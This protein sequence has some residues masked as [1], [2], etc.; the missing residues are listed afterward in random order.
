MDYE[1]AIR[2]VRA[3]ASELSRFVEGSTTRT[4]A[5]RPVDRRLLRG[6]SASPRGASDEEIKKAFRTLARELHPD[7]SDEPDA[8]ERFKEVVE[9]YEVLSKPER[10]ELYDRF[11]HAGLRSGG[12]VPSFD[13]GNSRDLF[14]AFFGDDL[15]GCRAAGASRRGADVGAEVEI[16]LVEA[17][18]RRRRERAV[19]GR[20]HVRRT[21]AAAAPSRARAPSTCPTCGGSGRLQQVSRTV[22]GEFVRTQT[23]PPLRRRRPDRRDAV[24]GLQRRRASRRGADARRRRSRAG[25]TTASG[26]ASRGEGHAGEPGG[27]AAT[28]TSSSTSG[29]TRASCARATTSSRPST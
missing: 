19:R 17:A 13:F 26:S 16:E 5:W 24:H 3:A 29:R 25:S 10:R 8:E 7:V 2:S 28:S 21:A 23:L 22:F 1:K 20:R 14:S 12:F 27:A 6:C 11:G 18:T 9:A 15:F 4:E